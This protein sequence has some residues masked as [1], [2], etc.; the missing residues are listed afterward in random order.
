MFISK[1]KQINQS[2]WLVDDLLCHANLS[3]MVSWTKLTANLRLLRKWKVEILTHC[4]R[5]S[6]KSL[7]SKSCPNNSMDVI[8]T[9]CIQKTTSGTCILFKLLKKV[10]KMRT[11]KLP[12]IR[13]L[14]FRVYYG[15]YKVYNVITIE[16]PL[17]LCVIQNLLF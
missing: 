10:K 6:R 7:V 8:I 3:H 4:F 14:E 11:H 17:K 13:I 15:Y 2:C 9:A 1:N 12:N 16:N 5:I